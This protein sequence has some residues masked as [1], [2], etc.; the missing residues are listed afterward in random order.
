MEIPAT[1]ALLGFEVKPVGRLNI[2][3]SKKRETRLCVSEAVNGCRLITFSAPSHCFHLYTEND[4]DARRI[5]LRAA[6]RV[7]GIARAH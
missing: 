5:I 3:E 1:L 4:R 6:A 2:L 7:R